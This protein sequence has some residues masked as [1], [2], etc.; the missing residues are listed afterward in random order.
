MLTS[1]M[2]DLSTCFLQFSFYGLA[3]NTG[4]HSYV[5]GLVGS[6]SNEGVLL[7]IRSP[8]ELQQSLS[9]TTFHPLYLLCPSPF[10]FHHISDTPPFIP[11]PLFHPSSLH[12]CF[13]V[14]CPHVT[15]IL[16]F[17]AY[18]LLTLSLFSLFHASTFVPSPRPSQANPAV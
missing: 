9:H 13:I 5:I 2:C 3:L 6:A 18:S 4:S 10:Y 14:I 15:M 7:D 8:M 1:V 12:P 17:L 11:V 16:S